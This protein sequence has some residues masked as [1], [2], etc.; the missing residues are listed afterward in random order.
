[1]TYPY[2][3]TSPFCRDGCEVRLRSQMASNS[4]H[5]RWTLSEVFSCEVVTLRETAEV[6]SEVSDWTSIVIMLIVASYLVAC[7]LIK[8]INA[9][10]TYI[11]HLTRDLFHAS[12]VPSIS[13][14]IRFRR[15]LVMKIDPII[16]PM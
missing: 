12:N 2:T 15:L 3:S 13:K 4:S 9:T 6:S 10:T 14:L 16:P 7:L 1:M 8:N 11:S 5:I